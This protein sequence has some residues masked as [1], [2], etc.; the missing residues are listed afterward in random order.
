MKRIAGILLLLVIAGCGK[1]KS[2]TI[3][4]SI[5]TY[6]G[7]INPIHQDGN[8]IVDHYNDATT[9][10]EYTAVRDEITA[11]LARIQAIGPPAAAAVAHNKIRQCW[12]LRKDATTLMMLAIQEY[13]TDRI[14]EANDLIR[15]SD[16][17]LSEASALLAT[18]G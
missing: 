10:S 3:D 13:D 5:P 15:Q 16:Q 12:G 8:A 7:Q 1:D 14:L 6:L 17:A 11:L 9:V 2:V 4:L 18:L